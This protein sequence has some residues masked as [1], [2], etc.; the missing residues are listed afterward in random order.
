MIRRRDRMLIAALVPQERID[1]RDRGLLRL[2]VVM[3]IL[4]LLGTTRLKSRGRMP[5]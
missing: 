1:L 4:T 3:S 2:A 5:C